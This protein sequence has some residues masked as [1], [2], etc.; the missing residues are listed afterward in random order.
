MCFLIGLPAGLAAVTQ[1]SHLE[2]SQWYPE[3][4]L[5]AVDLAL[6]EALAALVS[7]ESAEAAAQGAGDW[8]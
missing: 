2:T 6:L 3:V 8:G 7:H 4:D 1:L 5:K